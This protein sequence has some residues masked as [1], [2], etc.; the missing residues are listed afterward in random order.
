MAGGDRAERFDEPR[1]RRV[2]HP[3]IMLVERIE[4]M[5]VKQERL[6]RCA[7]ERQLKTRFPARARSRHRLERAVDELLIRVP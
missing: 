7:V 4:H 1:Q 3:I 5:L 6:H 2:D